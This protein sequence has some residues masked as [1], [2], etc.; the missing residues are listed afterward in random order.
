MVTEW[1]HLNTEPFQRLFNLPLGLL[2]LMKR[3]IFH[4]PWLENSPNQ[5]PRLPE[6]WRMFISTT[7]SFGPSD[8][9]EEYIDPK[10]TSVGIVEYSRPIHSR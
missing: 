4:R 5:S 6:W 7:E 3:S 9:Y 1:T 10:D 2:Q 8:D